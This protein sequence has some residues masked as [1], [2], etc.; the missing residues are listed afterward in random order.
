MDKTG[1]IN[2]ANHVTDPYRL[3]E[4]LG[5]PFFDYLINE[6]VK[7]A[8]EL[9]YHSIDNKIITRG[10]FNTKIDNVSEVG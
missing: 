9:F 5:T 6:D 7:R 1:I 4:V 8:K 2:Y 3:E 10:E